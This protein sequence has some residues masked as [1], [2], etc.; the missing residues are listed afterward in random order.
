MYKTTHF[1]ALLKNL[2]QQHKYITPIITA[3]DPLD[4]RE[5]C[6]F[7]KFRAQCPSDKVILIKYAKYGRMRVGNCVSTE[8][9]KVFSK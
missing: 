2:F 7:D 8:A 1:N 5:Y 3:A 6:L 9:G 4:N